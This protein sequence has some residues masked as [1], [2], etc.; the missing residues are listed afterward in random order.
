MNGNGD[1]PPTLGPQVVAWKEANLV[2][3][4]GELLGQDYRLEPWMKAVDY[5]L[6]EYDPVTLQRF[7]KRAVIGIGKGNA[8]TEFAAS[9]AAV[10]L[11]GPVVPTR[12]K[13]GTVTGMIRRSPNVPVAAASRDQ[14][15]LCF[16]ALGTM[17]NQGPLKPFF[18]VQQY[19]TK[20]KRR[21]GRTYRIAAEAGTQDGTLP[22]AFIADEVHEWVG[23][24]RRVHTVVRNSLRKRPGGGLELNISTAGDPSESD[25]LLELYDY[26]QK[27]RTGEVVDPSFLFVW[28]EPAT[29]DADL[30]DPEQLRAALRE[31][32]PSRWVD[33][34]SLA[35]EYERGTIK[36]NVFRRYHLNQWVATGMAFL[37][38]GAWDELADPLRD[39]DPKSVTVMAFDGSFNRDATALVGCTRDGHVFQWA[40]WEKPETAGK[41]W[42]VPRSEVDASVDDAMRRFPNMTLHCDPAK[43]TSEQ[44]Q[45]A[46]TYGDDRVLEFPQSNERMAPATAKFYAAVLEQSISH[47]GSQMLSRHLGNAVTKGLSGDR[48]VLRKKR[49]AAKIDAAVA[50]VMAVDRALVID[51]PTAP[52]R[53][54]LL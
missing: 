45:W 22:T 8:K 25:L 6:Y 20:L 44:E 27:L 21:T 51:T 7:V 48:F 50:A 34:E 18:D 26:G 2:H 38:F 5:R 19:E 54:T 46:D 52:P 28:F 43:W 15:N 23:R 49:D 35:A 31:A 11:A 3:G 53:V 47:D 42:R 40:G 32:N 4:E 9:V 1:R 14:A 13:D 29:E 39:I 24:R 36:E 37:P 16:G 17:I 30:N 41:N 12:R 10:E 33:V